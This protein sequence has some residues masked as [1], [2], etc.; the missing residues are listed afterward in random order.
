MSV[1]NNLGRRASEL[2]SKAIEHT[3]NYK[4]IVR[5]HNEIAEEERNIENIYLRIGKRYAAVNPDS[6]DE[7]L[8]LLLTDLKNAET[9]VAEKRTQIQILWG[10][11]RKRSF[12]LQFL[13][14]TCTAKCRRGNIRTGCL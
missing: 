7:G 13:R 10:G 11:N 3:R 4:D 9:K 14:S 5:F 2:G 12:I 6:E 1:F 8:L